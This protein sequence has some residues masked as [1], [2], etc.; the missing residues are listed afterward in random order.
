[1]NYD[2][3]TT[4]TLN[5]IRRDQQKYINQ[6]QDLLDSGQTLTPKTV[7][8]KIRRA[9]ERLA[10]FEKEALKEVKEAIEKAYSGTL[11]EVADELGIKLNIDA[12]SPRELEELEDFGS[13]YMHNYS[14]D[15]IKS[16]QM[17][18]QVGMLN[19]ES[20]SDAYERI[21]P[22]GNAVARPR[23]MIRDQVSL[24]R[25]RAI[26]SAYGAT[27]HPQDF[28]YYW[29]GPDDERT[30]AICAERKAH[31][32]YTWEQVKELDP[33][34][35]IQCRHRWRAVPKQRVTAK[36]VVE[37]DDEFV[38]DFAPPD[39]KYAVNKDLEAALK[40][41]AKEAF[42]NIPEGYKPLVKESMQAYSEDAFA[43]MNGMLRQEIG[44]FDDY[45]LLTDAWGGR[46]D[47]ED[48]I[49]GLHMVAEKSSAKHNFITWRGTSSKELD[50]L[51]APL[52]DVK[53]LDKLIG[54]SFT[55]KGFCSTSIQK[56]HAEYFSS[57]QQYFLEIEVPKGA[58][59]V[60][61]E[62]FSM[63]PGE[64]EFVLQSR[65]RFT[66]KDITRRKDGKGYNLIVRVVVE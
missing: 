34:P 38:P 13:Y 48:Y 42:D 45:E 28:D 17:Q 22:I 30:T 19:G 37:V 50:A 53:D 29:D 21:R 47:I 20:V 41:E 61:L 36:K 66:I 16:V 5:R 24:A 11:N 52:D 65:T 9:K 35:H 51:L 6:L 7:K 32:P 64:K 46:E 1:M 49:S 55:D 25:Q 8:T 58:K 15:V 4:Q 63:H 14:D 62:P 12:I 31:N 59:G 3:L 44:P 43:D 2:R 39:D 40:K 54:Q 23:V 56:A 18:L 33:H 26:V 10:D 27:G 57:G 60:Y